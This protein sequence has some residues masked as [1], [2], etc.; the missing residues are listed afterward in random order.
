MNHPFAP[1]AALFEKPAWLRTVPLATV[2][3]DSMVKRLHRGGIKK[4][5]KKAPSKGGARAAAAVAAGGGI[6][7]AAA[8]RANKAKAREKKKKTHKGVKVK[9]VV[10]V[11]GKKKKGGKK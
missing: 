7:K 10:G 9:K 1:F 3:T 5:P 8:K 4:A 2:R 11:G 6:G